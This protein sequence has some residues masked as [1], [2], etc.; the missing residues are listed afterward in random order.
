VAGS[1]LGLGYISSLRL[2]VF[3]VTPNWGWCALGLPFFRTGANR[4]GREISLLHN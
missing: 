3:V 2:R 1:G 4:R